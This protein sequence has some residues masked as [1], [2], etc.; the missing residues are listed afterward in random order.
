MW[1]ADNDIRAESYA[2]GGLTTSGLRE[3]VCRNSANFNQTC[4]ILIGVNDIMNNTT[5]TQIKSNIKSIVKYLTSKDYKLLLSTLPPTLH[6]SS[7]IDS[8]IRELNI[9]IQSYNTAPKVKVIYLNKLF[10]PYNQ[11][12]QQF[13]AQKYERGK[14]DY[15]HLAPAGLRVLQSLITE[16][17]DP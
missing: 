5:V 14:P 16:A 4:F 1:N 2:V 9:F 15:V 3:I 17:V 12:D 8:K 10:K 7:E 13:Y 6:K 11:H